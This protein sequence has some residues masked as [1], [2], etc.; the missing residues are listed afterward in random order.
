MKIDIPPNILKKIE[1]GQTITSEEARELLGE[2]NRYE[3]LR[4][5]FSIKVKRGNYWDTNLNCLAWGRREGIPNGIALAVLRETE[6]IRRLVEVASAGI[7]LS[8]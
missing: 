2:Y 6:R 8:R 3:L 1:N 4:F 5:R 7:D